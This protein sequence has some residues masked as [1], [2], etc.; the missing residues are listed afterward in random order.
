MACNTTISEHFLAAYGVNLDKGNYQSWLDPFPV[1]V[2]YL[3]TYF[4]QLIKLMGCSVPIKGTSILQEQPTVKGAK[5]HG[6]IHQRTSASAWSTK[7]RKRPHVD[8]CRRK[9]ESRLAPMSHR[10]PCLLRCTLTIRGCGLLG[11]VG[12]RQK[13][14]DSKPWPMDWFSHTADVK[15]T[16][17]K[18]R[19]HKPE[20][21]NPANKHRISLI[22]KKKHQISLI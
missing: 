17:T 1:N 20:N 13:S 15:K 12:S 2:K 14:S 9:L 11:Y 4:A 16:K 10:E 3:V 5:Q 22:F 6:N 8:V 21:R 7:A 19:F 18:H